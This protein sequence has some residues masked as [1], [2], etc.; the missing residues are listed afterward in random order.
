MSPE[1]SRQ[2]VGLDVDIWEME[3]EAWFADLKRPLRVVRY[4]RRYEA[5]PWKHERR[6]WRVVMSAP[7]E[8]LPTRQ[9][10]KG[11]R[12][13]WTIENRTFNLLT[14]E[15]SLTHNYRHSQAAIVGVLVLRRVAAC[16]T[17]AYHRFALARSQ[18]D[19]EG[20]RRWYEAVI[21]ED[22]VRFLDGAFFPAIGLDSS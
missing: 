15:Y 16:L 9:G 2:G 13:R 3:S 17:Q 1:P 4:R 19:P 11:G 21:E 14:R 7:V 20:F 22:W 5:K 10:G 18:P 8:I 12:C 6:E